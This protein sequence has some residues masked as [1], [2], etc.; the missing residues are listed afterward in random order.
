[1]NVRITL[2]RSHVGREKSM[3]RDSAKLCTMR[4]NFDSCSELANLIQ[5]SY[6]L[7]HAHARLHV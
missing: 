4:V 7:S 2:R 3:V 1:M 5:M 6:L